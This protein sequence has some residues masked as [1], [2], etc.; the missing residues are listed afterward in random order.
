MLVFAL[1]SLDPEWRAAVSIVCLPV[2]STPTAFRVNLETSP[3]N[4]NMSHTQGETRAVWMG[5]MLPVFN[6]QQ[7]RT[8]GYG[9]RGSLWS[10]RMS[11]LIAAE[12]PFPH[13]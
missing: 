4:S 3:V 8:Y 1:L 11:R 6:S 7:S 10:D 5:K 12:M 2:L 9:E 13:T